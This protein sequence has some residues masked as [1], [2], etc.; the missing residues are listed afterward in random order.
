ML[1]DDVMVRF[2]L[3]TCPSVGKKKLKLGQGSKEGVAKHLNCKT[4][5]FVFFSSEKQS[6][7][8]YTLLLSLDFSG[9]GGREV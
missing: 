1:Q 9:F 8:G 3:L 5:V 6:R 2:V 7:S 4:E